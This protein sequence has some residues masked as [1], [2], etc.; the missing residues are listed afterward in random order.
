MRKAYE[1]PSVTKQGRVITRT[2]SSGSSAS[3]DGAVGKTTGG[4]SVTGNGTETQS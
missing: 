2:L 3:P 4:A 1:L